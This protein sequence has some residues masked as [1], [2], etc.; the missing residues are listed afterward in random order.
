M[1]FLEDNRSK[2]ISRSKMAKEERDGKTRYQKRLNTKM[3]SS[4]KEY[5]QIDMNKLFKDNILDLNILI[6][7]ETKDYTVKIKFGGLLDTLHKLLKNNQELDLRLMIKAL[8]MTFNQDDVYVSCNCPDF[9]YR[10]GYYAT[11][12]KI[13]SGEPQL[14]PSKETNPEDDLGPACKHTLL[15][16][17]NTTWIIKV[18]SVIINYMKYMEKHKPNLYSDIIYPA[19]YD[20]PYEEPVQLTM[21]DDEQEEDDIDKANVYARTKSQFKPGNEY[22]FKKQDKPV[23]GQEEIDLDVEEEED[24]I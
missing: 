21:F 22:R 2:L 24:E 11:L 4:N 5:N 7:G 18:A 13:N 14:I 15:V 10:F 12:N 23:E 17:A 6:H 19:V 3:S 1:I 16:L 8:T 9:F 20:K